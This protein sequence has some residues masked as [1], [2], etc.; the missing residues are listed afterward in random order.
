MTCSSTSPMLTF[1]GNGKLL[2]T[3]EYF[4]LDGALALALPSPLGQSLTIR[5]NDTSQLHWQSFDKQGQ[6]WFS[7]V[8][9]P[10]DF[11]FTRATHT[12]IAQRLQQILTAI[13]KQQ[14]Q[15]LRDGIGRDVQTRLEFPR[16]WGLGTSST[17]IY[18]LSSW[19][20]VDPY[21]LLR[22]T[23]GGSGY[24]IA[25]AAATQ[26]IFYQIEA[27][28]AQVQSVDFSPSFQQDLYFV[29]LGKK[30]NSRSGIQHYRAKVQTDRGLLGDIS[31]L[32]KAVATAS[33][34]NSFGQLLLQHEQLVAQAVA[35]PRAQ[36]RYFVDFD[37]V[38]KSLGA[39]GGDFVLAV[40]HLNQDRTR[41]YFYEKGFRTVVSYADMV[42]FASKQL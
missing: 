25:C 7:V 14:P 28:C 1:R 16:L 39:W 10:R 27:G 22:D 32:T 20:A 6:E 26:P 15:F 13:R 5:P 30:Q 24:D 11:S 4:V 19:A 35:L 12:D 21:L 38:V 3:G 17:L 36:E 42:T 33:T 29:Y 37:G 40:S 41:T 23:F 9:E 31:A 34:K 8:F 18:A 2:L